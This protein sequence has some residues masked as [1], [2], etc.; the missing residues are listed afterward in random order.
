[1]QKIK[2]RKVYEGVIV[3]VSM[4]TFDIGD[5]QTFT[6]EV[7]NHPGGVCIA[8]SPDDNTSFLMVKQFRFGANKELLEFPAGLIDPHEPHE[9]SAL[10]ELEE[11]TGYKAHA[12]VYLGQLYLSPGGSDEV[13]HMYYAYD[14]EKT[15][16]NLDE[17]ESLSVELVSLDHLI[18]DIHKGYIEDG[19]TVALA[20]KVKAYIEQ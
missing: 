5:H 4:D 11:E 7:V 13:I 20:L 14:L 16:Q 8:A 3:D 1:M 12:L 10:R 9:Q 6:A 2:T 15:Q 18:Q 19:K 17:T